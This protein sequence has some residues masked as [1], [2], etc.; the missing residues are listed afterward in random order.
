ML[1]PRGPGETVAMSGGVQ[2][3][4]GAG[5]ATESCA[6]R[7]FVFPRNA[8]PMARTTQSVRQQRIAMVRFTS[9]LLRVNAPTM[10]LTLPFSDFQVNALGFPACN[11]RSG[12]Q[13]FSWHRYRGSMRQM[14]SA[15]FPLPRPRF[16]PAGAVA[17]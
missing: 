9:V 1:S 4:E 12:I 11:A 5:A 8:R 3:F 15:F 2:V 10:D 13:Q 16:R 14:F 7:E 17:W 6:P